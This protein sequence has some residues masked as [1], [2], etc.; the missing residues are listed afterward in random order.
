MFYQIYMLHLLDGSVV[1]AAEKYDLPANKGLIA[2][3]AAADTNKL[4]E[5]GDPVTGFAYIPKSSIIYISTGG[6]RKVGS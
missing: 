6:V 2:K 4:F 3:Y 5:I 1:E